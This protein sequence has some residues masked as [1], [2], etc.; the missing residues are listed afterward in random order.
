MSRTPGA[1]GLPGKWPAND[2]S[3]CEMHLIATSRRPGSTVR[4]LSSIR[5]GHRCGRRR[6]SS[7]ASI[8]PDVALV[9]T[10]A[11]TSVTVAPLDA[12]DERVDRPE[13][14]HLVVVDRDEELFFDPDHQ[15]Q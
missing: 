6:A 8:R 11:R 5:N 1:M 14:L 12:V 15:L 2:Q 3:P 4:T 9:A 13:D 7:C 10:G